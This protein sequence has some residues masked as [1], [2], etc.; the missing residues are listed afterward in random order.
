MANAVKVDN[1]AF[2]GRV[3]KRWWC[4]IRWYFDMHHR[5]LGW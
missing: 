3:L 2:N 5:V 1:A 4:K